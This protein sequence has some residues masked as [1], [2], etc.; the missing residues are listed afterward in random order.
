MP[1]TICAVRASM[2]SK[3]AGGV[4]HALAGLYGVLVAGKFASRV[5]GL[6]I[7]RHGGNVPLGGHS[8]DN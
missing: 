2:R 8:W 7:S 4:F 6:C 1:S 5:V 3:R